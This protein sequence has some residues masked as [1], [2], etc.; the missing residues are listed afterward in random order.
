MLFVV[1]APVITIFIFS[2]LLK[3]TAGII[4]PI[5]DK[6]LSEMVYSVSKNIT[7]LAVAILGVAFMFFVMTLLI[8]LTGNFGYI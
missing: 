3:L 1:L 6:R 2:L 5:C 7:T 8:M 4:E